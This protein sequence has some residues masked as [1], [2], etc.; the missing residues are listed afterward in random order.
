MA[1]CFCVTNQK[2]MR[3]IKNVM[4]A[5]VCVLMLACGKKE[6]RFNYTMIKEKMQLEQ[7]K[8]DAFDEITDR[9]MKKAHDNFNENKGNREVALQ[10]LQRIFADQDEEIAKLVSEQQFDIYA[11][12]ISIER[13]GREKY[14]MMLIEKNLALDSIQTVKFQTANTAFYTA[15]FNEHDNY[16]GKPDVYRQYY[17]ELNKSRETAIQNI[18]SEAQ[19]KHY[20]ELYNEYKIGKSEH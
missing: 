11:A 18:L 16:H 20:Q 17:D 13:E 19:F 8:V 15:L 4:V 10:N 2:D 9:Y 7:E 5:L 3:K 6:E 12:E 14:N 1:L